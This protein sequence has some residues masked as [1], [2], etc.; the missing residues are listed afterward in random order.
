MKPDA[1]PT[2][3]DIVSMEI[4]L[5]ILIELLFGFGYNQLVAYLMK[6]RLMHVSV[7]VVIGVIVTL[8]IPSAF[9]FDCQM[10]F[11]H[12][13][14][15]LTACFT[16][17]GLPMI[18]G[19]M[20]RTVKEKDDKK[21]R[22]LGNA[23]MRIRDDVVMELTDMAREIAEKAKKDQLSWNDMPDYVNRLHFVIGSLR[24]L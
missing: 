2:N 9:W 17:S 20:Q 10:H 7:T 21:R 8:S 14:V 3:A 16:A 4:A 13:C 19:S 15:L 5:V 18:F 12:A 6:H 1:L 23:A 22:P 24:T 11:W